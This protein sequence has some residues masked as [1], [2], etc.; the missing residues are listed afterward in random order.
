MI[1]ASSICAIGSTRAGSL[2]S[3]ACMFQPLASYRVY[4]IEYA[5]LVCPWCFFEV[6]VDLLD[7][8]GFGLFANSR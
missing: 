7:K 4:N 2:P 5:Q 6:S 3:F 1:Y 8:D